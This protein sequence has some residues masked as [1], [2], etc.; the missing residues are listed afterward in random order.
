MAKIKTTE[1]LN[2]GIRGDKEASRR[3]S[4]FCGAKEN[5]PD[6]TMPSSRRS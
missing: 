3:E 6:A 2:E 1:T 5:H 4:Q